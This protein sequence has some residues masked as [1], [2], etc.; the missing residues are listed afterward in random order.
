V[1]NRYREKWGFANFNL[2]GNCNAD[3]YFCLG[4]DLNNEFIN[5]NQ[6]CTHYKYM[7][8]F[9]KFINSCKEKDI[10]NIYITGQTA[11]GLQYKYLLEL[12]LY[13]K[14]LG[15]IVGV[16]T[17]GYL[18]LE[19]MDII[20]EMNGE[21]GYTINSLNNANNYNIMKRLDIPEWEKIFKTT[22]DN[23][24]VSIV[25]NRYN[26]NEIDNIIKFVSNFKKIK[27][28]QLRRICTENRHDLLNLDTVIFNKFFNEF[29]KDNKKIDTFYKAE[30]FNKYNKN[31]IFWRTT[32]TSVN[33]IN[34]FSD[35]ILSNEYFIVE[36]YLKAK[37]IEEINSRFNL[38]EA[39][40]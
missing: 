40:S 19:K 13:L 7:K 31:I 18:A 25:I 12:V 9:H 15:F 23:S 37:K 39:L 22:S 8:N 35:G 26:M 17:N 3:C 30:I 1:K 24:R 21:I 27:Y 38:D 11:D 28:I 16:R 2:L 14:N 4:K 5:E 6:L 20:K 32:E 29:S 36:G 33:S 10:K 34:Y